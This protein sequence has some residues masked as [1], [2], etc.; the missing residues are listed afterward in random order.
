VK[1]QASKEVDARLSDFEE[2]TEKYSDMT[3]ADY[4]KMKRESKSKKK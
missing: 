2:Y 1:K 4:Q 3:Y